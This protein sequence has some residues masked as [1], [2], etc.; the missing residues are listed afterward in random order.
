M[1]NKGARRSILKDLIGLVKHMRLP[2]LMLG[3]IYHPAI[4]DA[5]NR[6]CSWGVVLGEKTT[7]KCWL[8]GFVGLADGWKATRLV[9]VDPRVRRLTQ[10]IAL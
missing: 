8:V 1:I 2:P 3:E 6:I 9:R 5:S 7:R 10:L 4:L